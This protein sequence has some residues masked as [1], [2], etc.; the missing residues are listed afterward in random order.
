MRFSLPLL[1]R[2]KTR[3]KQINRFSAYSAILIVMLIM[4]A[5]LVIA[6]EYIQR[7]SLQAT[8]EWVKHNHSLFYFNYTINL[9][10]ALLIYCIV[11]SLTLSLGVT[12][13]LLFTI[14]LISYF[15]SKMIGE[16]FVPWDVLL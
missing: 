13:T 14:S 11:G 1:K 5:L 15:K 10:L 3:R 8:M 4:P 12:S 2:K 7:G 6:V 16:P 9:C